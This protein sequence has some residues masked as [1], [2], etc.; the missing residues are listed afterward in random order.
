MK[1]LRILSLAL[2]SLGF[3]AVSSYATSDVLYDYGIHFEGTIS[4]PKNPSD[5]VSPTKSIPLTK[6]NLLKISSNTSVDPSTTKFFYD[7][8]TSSIV[9]ASSDKNTIYL[10]VLTYDSGEASWNPSSL[11]TVG[12]G[13]CSMLN[14]NLPGSHSSVTIYHTS[15]TYQYTE[16]D[17]VVAYGSYVSVPTVIHLTLTLKGLPII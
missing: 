13:P 15:G 5:S 17:K 9:L 11:K 12:A 1:S 7:S 8:S 3:T 6:A 14:G 4:Q 10:T 16:T 2:L